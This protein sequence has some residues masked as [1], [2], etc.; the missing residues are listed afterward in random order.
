[1]VQLHVLH[2]QLCKFYP[3]ANFENKLLRVFQLD[4]KKMIEDPAANQV[5][6][7]AM[8]LMIHVFVRTGSL[9]HAMWKDFDL[10]CDDPLWIVPNYNMK[11]KIDF[12]VPL[13]PQAVKVIEEMKQFSGPDGYVFTQKINST[14]FFH[15]R[16]C[17]V[18]P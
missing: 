14:I 10:E 5:T 15:H 9:R 1:M 12:H 7:L 16:S 13:S 3:Y 4:L 2:L 11:N 17:E 8:L 6:K 18:K